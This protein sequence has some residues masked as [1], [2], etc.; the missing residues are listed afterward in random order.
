LELGRVGFCAG[1]TRPFCLPFKGLEK[2]DS[3]HGIQHKSGLY[4]MPKGQGQT[5]QRGVRKPLHLSP[6]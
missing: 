5:H 2:E 4:N 3:S 6:K 1:T